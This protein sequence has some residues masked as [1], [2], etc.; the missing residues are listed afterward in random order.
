MTV[1]Y[2]LPVVPNGSPRRQPFSVSKVILTAF[3]GGGAWWWGRGMACL[4]ENLD[5]IPKV[6][7]LKIVKII[8]DDKK[9]KSYF[10]ILILTQREKTPTELAE[11]A[12]E[13]DS[14]LP[15]IYQHRNGFEHK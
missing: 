14:I 8:G 7:V 1:N 12:I 2:L 11:K 13:K 6:N 5:L 15:N 10:Y 3:W 4:S 9:S